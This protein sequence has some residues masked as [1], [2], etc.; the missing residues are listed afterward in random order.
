MA[1]DHVVNRASLDHDGITVSADELH[2]VIPALIPPER[3]PPRTLC[4]NLLYLVGLSETPDTSQSSR[5]VYMYGQFS[6]IYV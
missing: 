5:V 4:V 2:G 6:I 3:P 1:S